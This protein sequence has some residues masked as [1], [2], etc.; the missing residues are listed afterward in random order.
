MANTICSPVAGTKDQEKGNDTHGSKVIVVPF[1]GVAFDRDM[2]R[3]ANSAPVKSKDGG[4]GFERPRN[5]IVMGLTRSWRLS[6]LEK[7]QRTPPLWS[8][9]FEGRGAESP[10][11]QRVCRPQSARGLAHSTPWRKSPQ[12]PRFAKRLAVRPRCI[13]TALMARVGWRTGQV[14]SSDKEQNLRELGFSRTRS[15]QHPLIPACGH[16]CRC[17]RAMRSRCLLSVKA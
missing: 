7:R 5:G 10:R 11:S 1:D 2:Q 9:T 6:W 13:G 12:A 14:S 16:G 17:F 8:R 3:L 15:N 4:R